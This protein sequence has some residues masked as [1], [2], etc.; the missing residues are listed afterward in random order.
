MFK[1]NG[2]QQAIIFLFTLEDS[3]DLFNIEEPGA[4]FRESPH[5]VDW[6]CRIKAI[7]W[8]LVAIGLPLVIINIITF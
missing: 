7:F 2:V 5:A 1:K 8:S 3:S 4:F 6:I